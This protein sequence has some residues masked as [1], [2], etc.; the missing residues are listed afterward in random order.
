MKVLNLA[1]KGRTSYTA[2]VWGKYT[3]FPPEGDSERANRANQV[4]RLNVKALSHG[5][6]QCNDHN[7]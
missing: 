7:C 1:H 6:E 5:K 3:T 4:N 2:P